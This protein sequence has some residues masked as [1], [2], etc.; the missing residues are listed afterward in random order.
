M[1]QRLFYRSCRRFVCDKSK[2]ISELKQSNVITLPLSKSGTI[3]S[4]N[5]ANVDSKKDSAKIDSPTKMKWKDPLHKAILATKLGAVANLFLAVTKGVI[6]YSISSTGLIAD[7]ANSMGDLVC[8]SVVY[9]TVQEAR[10]KPSPDRPW[11]RGKFE[12]LGAL[13]VGGLLLATGT[14]IG[15]SALSAAVA[16]TS[17][18][19]LTSSMLSHYNIIMPISFDLSLK[20]VDLPIGNDFN[21]LLGL[22]ISGLS[23]ISKEALF[24]YT[25]Y[26][27]NQANSAVVVANAW[28]HRSDAATSTAVFCGLVGSMCG[29]PLADPLAGLLVAGVIVR[30]AVT[31]GLDSLKDLS[32]AP[33]SEEETEI[34]RHTCLNVRGIKSV[35][36]I[37]AR[38]SGPY[39]FVEVTVGVLGTIS[40]SAAHRLSE[41][42]RNELLKVHKGRVANA[43]VIVEPLGTSGLGE[44]SPSGTRD[45]DHIEDEIRRI[46]QSKVTAVIDVSEVQI[47]YKDDGGIAAKVDIILPLS[48]SIREAHRIAV[49]V[50]K[51]LES[52]M[53]GLCDIDIDL[54][55]DED[56]DNDDD[57]NNEDYVNSGNDDH[58][59]HKKKNKTF[60]K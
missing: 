25:L 9:F 1:N 39:L 10:R 52:K 27:G 33:A 36:D 12:P 38:K 22:A 26:A 60:K 14:G 4:D 51:E 58:K 21:M 2:F 3:K 19:Q 55:L 56:Y 45:H 7:A 32:D 31:I 17:D 46:I 53:E 48:L 41:L 49:M 42:T 35:K 30:Q 34:L 40:A 18:L 50:R 59:K 16:L 29:Y 37:R 28:Q 11:G 57:E 44:L 47:Y 24:R 5:S 13:T 8:D 23:I 20:G 6:G 54:E 15:Y 43:T